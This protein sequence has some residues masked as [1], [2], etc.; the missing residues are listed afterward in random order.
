MGAHYLNFDRSQKFESTTAPDRRN[1]E[2][3]SLVIKGFDTLSI[4]VTKDQLKQ[5][6]AAIAAETGDT[7]F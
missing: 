7:P 1:P 2:L 4:T 3:V 5:I 6:G